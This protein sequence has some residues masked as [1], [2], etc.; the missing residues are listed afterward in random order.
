MAIGK[1]KTLK[2]WEVS[3]ALKLYGC[4]YLIVLRRCLEKD[5]RIEYKME[6]TGQDPCEASPRKKFNADNN[7]MKGD[8]LFI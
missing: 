5:S 6:I 1:G 7:I 3:K 2:A 4:R 8:Y